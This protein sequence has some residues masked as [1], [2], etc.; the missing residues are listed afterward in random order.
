MLNIYLKGCIQ[1]YLT[2]FTP[3]TRLQWVNRG[4]DQR[5][6]REENQSSIHLTGGIRWFVLA[7]WENPANMHLKVLARHLHPMTYPGHRTGVT[8]GS[9]TQPGE[10]VQLLTPRNG[11]NHCGQKQR[12]SHRCHTGMHRMQISD[13]CWK[14]QPWSLALYNN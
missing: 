13:C 11:M 9:S 4:R 10:S 14:T 2:L 1:S 5:H 3:L 12:R 6:R 7:L 8:T